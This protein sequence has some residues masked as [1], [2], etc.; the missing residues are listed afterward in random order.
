MRFECCIIKDVGK[1]TDVSII[2]D[3]RIIFCVAELKEEPPELP[4]RR[5]L[6]QGNSSVRREKK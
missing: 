4:Y 6:I 2:M 5:P 3:V 1:I